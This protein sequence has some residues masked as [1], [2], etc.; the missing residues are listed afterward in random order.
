V[1]AREFAIPAVVGASGAGERV[2][3]GDLVRVNGS[4]GVV[5]ILG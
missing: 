4:S 3:T 2:R 5:E 1:V